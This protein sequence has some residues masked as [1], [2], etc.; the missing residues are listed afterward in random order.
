GGCGRY[1]LPALG[2][3]SR[4]RVRKASC[5]IAFTI[6]GPDRGRKCAFDVPAKPETRV[7]NAVINTKLSRPISKRQRLTLIGIAAR[8]AGECE[9][10]QH[11]IK[12]L[13]LVHPGI[14]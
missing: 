2:V 12:R 9:R 14:E 7:Q 4:E 3:R 10:C 13:S 1:Q 5:L 11:D 8:T 6:V